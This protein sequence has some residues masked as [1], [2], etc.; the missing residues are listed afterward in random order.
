MGTPDPI[1]DFDAS[2]HLPAG[3]YRV[4]L[5]EIRRRLTWNRHRRRLFNGL[6]RAVANLAS[7]GVRWVWIDGSFTTDKERPKDIDGCWE[8]VQPM[9]VEKL[10][11]VFLDVLPPRRAMKRKY[12]V[13]FLIAQMPLAEMSGPAQLTPVEFFQFDRD[14]TQKG[15]LLLHIGRER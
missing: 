9:Q 3:V 5:G 11:P 12:G 14:G 7:A 2:G 13:D 10:D 4:S 8:G 1:P 15:I 6:R